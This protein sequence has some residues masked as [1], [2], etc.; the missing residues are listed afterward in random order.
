MSETLT[1]RVSMQSALELAVSIFQVL[2]AD[3]RKLHMERKKKF[4]GSVD[5]QKIEIF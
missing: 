4:P 5:F 2:K 3:K 1:C